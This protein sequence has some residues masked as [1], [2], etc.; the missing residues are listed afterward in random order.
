LE[1]V[2]LLL[3]HGAKVEQ[4]NAM[5]RAAEKGR[6]DVLT[7]LFQ[8][9]ADVNE[10]QHD[11]DP[12]NSSKIRTRMKKEYSITSDTLDYPKEWWR[13]ETPLHF[14]VLFRQVEAT[15]WLVERGADA[16]I[17][18][19]EGWT[20]RDMA[21]KMDDAGILEALKASTVAAEE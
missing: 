2:K 11:H 9:G 21:I 18:G 7:L 13:D 15:A 12:G 19:S 16:N 3:E 20:A 10:Q 1:E 17:K 8:Y 4:S 14:S 5:H 6:I